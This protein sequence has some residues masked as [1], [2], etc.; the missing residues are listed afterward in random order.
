[1][2]APNQSVNSK[3]RYSRQQLFAP[4]G[5]EGQQRLA[6]SRILI[7]G[8]GA[9]GSALADTFVRAGVGDVTLIDRDY[10]EW[11]NLQ[12]QHLYTE[13]DAIDHLPKAI[14]AERRLKAI[15]SDTVVRGV[16]ADVSVYEIEEW[17]HDRDLIIDATDNF[18]TRM[19]INDYAQK[20]NIPWIYGA[21][22]SSNGIFMM[23]E[24]G[25]TP[26]FH[27]LLETVP[28]GGPTCDTAGIIAPA[29][30]MTAAYQ[31]AEALKWLTGNRD[32]LLRKLVS[33]DLWKNQHTAISVQAAKR[34]D[35]PS[36]GDN[37]TYPYLDAANHRKTDI[38]CGR[39]T[40]QI[41]PSKSMTVQLEEI[42]ARL[43]KVQ[44]LQV[45]GNPYLLSIQLEHHRVVLFRDGR[46]LVHGTKDAAEA[47]TIA[48]R[49]FG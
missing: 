38:L 42:A 10:V 35:C 22:V 37:P 20:N 19:L 47:R 41:R 2:T 4:I 21:C 14:A 29:V 32:A 1:M 18:D 46:L 36:C 43:S 30:H 26:C 39:E 34:P 40:I 48:D 7:I 24:P 31:A 9:L 45:K 6:E 44:G 3:E 28:M 17:A 25:I 11:S 27:C 13:Q 12:R 8:A 5:E 23:V 33:F 16:V 49:L 15:Q